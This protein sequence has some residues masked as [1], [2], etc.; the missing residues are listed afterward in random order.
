MR[1][2]RFR[3]HPLQRRGDVLPVVLGGQEMTISKPVVVLVVALIVTMS[4]LLLYS[5]W[6]I[7]RAD[8]E[9][10]YLL[11]HCVLTNQ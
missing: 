5:T 10:R 9:M 4:Y 6:E 1:G 11:Q 7:Y 8:Y 2:G 3:E